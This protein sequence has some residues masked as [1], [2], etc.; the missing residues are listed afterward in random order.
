MKKLEDM[1]GQFISASASLKNNIPDELLRA[2]KRSLLSKI[3]GEVEPQQDYNSQVE[4]M[5]QMDLIEA[6][7]Y[8]RHAQVT[9]AKE[10]GK[11]KT[12]RDKEPLIEDV[13]AKLEM[14]GAEHRKD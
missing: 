8:K 4:L 5:K 7:F 9:Q 12:I 14:I 11:Y 10:K 2:V 3:L 13:K 6:Q 1:A